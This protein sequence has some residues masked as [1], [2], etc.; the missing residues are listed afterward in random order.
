MWAVSEP[1]GGSG[2]IGQVDLQETAEEL[3]CLHDGIG[4]KDHETHTGEW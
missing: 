2:K 1:R 3:H 4:E